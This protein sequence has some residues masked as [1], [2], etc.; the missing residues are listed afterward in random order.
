MTSH[1]ERLAPAD[2][3]GRVCAQPIY[4]YPPGIAEY[5]PGERIDGGILSLGIKSAAVVREKQS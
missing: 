5:V 1:F 4:S 3:V 2:A